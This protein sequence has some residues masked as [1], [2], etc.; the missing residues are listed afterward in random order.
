MNTKTVTKPKSVVPHAAAFVNTAAVSSVKEN[1]E[2]VSVAPPASAS[3]SLETK[4]Q[5]IHKIREWV[6]IDNE[7]RMLQKEMNKRKQE[8]K[9][10]SKEL[11]EVMRQNEI[12]AFDLKDGQLV[13][14][15][16]KTKKPITKKTL[17]GLLSTYFKGNTEKASELN[18]FIMENREEVIHE[19]LVRTFH[20]NSD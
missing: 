7:F 12:D 5:L 2:T 16:T 1:A 15:K 8:K 9:N 13:Y 10:I 18:E 3:A 6:K 20:S 4:E 11:L 14:A 19:K 17:F